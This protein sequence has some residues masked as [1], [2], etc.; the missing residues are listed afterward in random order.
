MRRSFLHRPRQLSQ[1]NDDLV[2]LDGVEQK[3]QQLGVAKRIV[4]HK[5]K[6]IPKITSISKSV[7]ND[8]LVYWR[9]KVQL[10][11]DITFIL[12]HAYNGSHE[13]EQNMLDQVKR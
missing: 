2:L 5:I 7:F 9:A 10:I 11:T 12:Y 13:S 3:P 1:S 4:E 8:S 6:Q